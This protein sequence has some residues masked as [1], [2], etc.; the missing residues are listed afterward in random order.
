[1]ICKPARAVTQELFYLFVTHP[2]ML[3]VVQYRDEHVEMREQFAQA[4]ATAQFDRAV[5]A[6]A[7]VG[8]FLIERTTLC[9]NFIPERL[10]QSPQEP[11][12]PAAR[13]DGNVGFQGERGFCQF[14][15]V[16]ASSR[17]RTAEHLR[18]G[19]AEE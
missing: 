8:K 4:N 10:E 7:P 9:H 3:L 16:L 14:R 6:F 1:M 13:Q 11:L 19:H 15:A 2:V 18:D 12:A 17:Q 5:D